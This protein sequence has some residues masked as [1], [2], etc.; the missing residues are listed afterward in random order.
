MQR[1]ARLTLAL[2]ALTVLTAVPTMAGNFDESVTPSPSPDAPSLEAQ[3]EE[4]PALTPVP[5]PEDVERPADPEQELFFEA[6]YACD[7]RTHCPSPSCA[8]LV[9]RN[10]VNCFC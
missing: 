9:I 1:A 3:L 6:I 5:S 2:L 7:E 4:P 10:E 8:C